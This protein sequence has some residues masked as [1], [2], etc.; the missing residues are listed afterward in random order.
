MIDIHCHILPGID[1]GP[2]TIETSLAMA[3]IAFDDGIDTII[4]TPH[5][6][7]IRVNRESVV[8]A[9]S[10]LNQELLLNNIK[11][12]VL[13]G[14]EI[15]YHLVAELA[16]RQT[17]AES[18]YVLVEFP[19][20]HLPRGALNTFYS[21]LAKGFKPIVAHP[22][23]NHDVIMN[24]QLMENITDSGV[25]LQITAASITGQLGPDIQRCSH[26]L[27]KN[28]MV[29]YIAT[30]SHSPTFRE[31]ALTKAFRSVTKLLGKEKSRVLFYDNPKKILKVKGKESM[32][33]TS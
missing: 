16:E 6:D 17:L 14:Y 11:V 15:P 22:E 4:A 21:L 29:H 30:D 24:P 10:K 33:S 2:R 28:D 13:P 1:D 5:T 26:Y 23:R 3:S 25:Y 9:V 31:P 32:Y 18:E 7:G 8:Q 12:H 27:L 19:H 20:T